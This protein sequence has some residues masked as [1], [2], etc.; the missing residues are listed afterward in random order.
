M[1]YFLNLFDHRIISS[2]GM[3]IHLNTTEHILGNAELSSFIL[4][5]FCFVLLVSHLFIGKAWIMTSDSQIQ[6]TFYYNILYNL[7]YYILNIG[8]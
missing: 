2:I 8:V 6:F 7:K 1:K 4:Q 5:L 3:L